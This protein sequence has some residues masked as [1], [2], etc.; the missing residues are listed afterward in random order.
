MKKFPKLF[1]VIFILLL[2]ILS[3]CGQESTGESGSGSYGI[4]VF[5]KNTEYTAATRDVENY[6]VDEVVGKINR[7]ISLEKVPTQNGGSN[8][9]EEGTKIY[10]IV[11]EE[12]K[13]YLEQ[14]GE[15]YVLTANE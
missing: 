2:T 10:S 4:S 14:K 5:Y 9:F 3:A 13:I 7:K 11:D 1:F 15:S 6:I 12:Y 8:F